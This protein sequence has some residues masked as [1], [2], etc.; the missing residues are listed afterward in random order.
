MNTPDDF[1]FNAWNIAAAKPVYSGPPQYAGYNAFN[2]ARSAAALIIYTDSGRLG[3]AY[4]TY[5]VRPEFS[6][7]S[8][9]RVM[10]L[11]HT[12]KANAVFADGHAESCSRTA[13][14]SYGF[15]H[16]MLMSGC[17]ETGAVY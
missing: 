12:G 5:R 14:E 9:D 16:Y 17:D 10:H 13:A 7:G 8:G 15:K 1:G 11:R 3:S 4:Q 2:G 6:S